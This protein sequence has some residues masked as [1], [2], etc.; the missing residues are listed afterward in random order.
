[1]GKYC[2]KIPTV[3]MSRMWGIPSI[4]NKNVQIGW[5]SSTLRKC[6]EQTRELRNPW[7]L[8]QWLQG[9]Q[10]WSGSY[11]LPHGLLP[12]ETIVFFVF[13]KVH[14]S[15]LVNEPLI[16][17]IYSASQYFQKKKEIG[18]LPLNCQSFFIYVQI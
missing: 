3:L 6:P 9:S 7:E 11:T 12:F 18:H 8:I 15:S 10:G 13:Y 2:L 5:V 1:M 4:P 14:C 17:W 16:P